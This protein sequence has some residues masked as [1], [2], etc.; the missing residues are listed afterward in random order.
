MKTEKKKQKWHKTKENKRLDL[1]CQSR[2]LFVG[3]EAQLSTV[4]RE[5]KLKTALGRLRVKSLFVLGL[6]EL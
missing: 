2:G 4:T 3:K 5:K 6:E 1:A